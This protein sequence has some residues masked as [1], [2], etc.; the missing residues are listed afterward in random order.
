MASPEYTNQ[1]KELAQQ[2]VTEARFSEVKRV[3]ELA[4]VSTLYPD[5]PQAKII[6]FPAGAPEE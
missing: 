5:L 1:L 3:A 6:Y 4:T 2:L